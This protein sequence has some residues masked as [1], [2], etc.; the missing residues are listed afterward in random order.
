MHEH[1]HLRYAKCTIAG[2][3]VTPQWINGARKIFS[4]NCRD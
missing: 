4:N 1:Q 3:C 2:N